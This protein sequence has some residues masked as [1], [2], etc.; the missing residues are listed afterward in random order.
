MAMNPKELAGHLKIR[1]DRKNTH[2]TVRDMVVVQTPYDL[3]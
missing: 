3:T 2:I 1:M